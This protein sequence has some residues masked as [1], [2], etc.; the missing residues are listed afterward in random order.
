M[1]PVA[2]TGG[3]IP[4]ATVTAFDTI[5]LFFY[6]CVSVICV[7]VICC[8]LLYLADFCLCCTIFTW[9]FLSFS[10]FCLYRLVT[11]IMKTLKLFLRNFGKTCDRS[12]VSERMRAQVLNPPG[13]GK[14]AA[15]PRTAGRNRPWSS[16]RRPSLGPEKVREVVAWREQEFKRKKSHKS[17]IFSGKFSTSFM[18]LWWSENFN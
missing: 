10:V 12:H 2:N 18:K 16:P 15:D 1:V 6:K 14:P 4:P 7:C 5:V 11:F 13:Y 3:V 9:F 8:F 17:G